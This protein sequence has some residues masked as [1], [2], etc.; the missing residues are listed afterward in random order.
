MN[1]VELISQGGQADCEQWVQKQGSTVISA[2]RGRVAPAR[3]AL[4]GAAGAN[5]GFRMVSGPRPGGLRHHSP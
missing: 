3:G 2:R 5:L 4:R 1:Q